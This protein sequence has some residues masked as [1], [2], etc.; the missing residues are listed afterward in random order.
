VKVLGKEPS[1]HRMTP[2]EK[3]AI[4]DIIYAY[5]SS[6]VRTSEN[7]IARIAINFLVEDY[8]ENGENSVLHK[9]LQ[10]LNE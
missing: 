3:K 4:V 10:A 7:E 2:E 5:K 9:V 6:G 8:G 1:T